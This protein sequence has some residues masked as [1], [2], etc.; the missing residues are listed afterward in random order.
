MACTNPPLL[1][2]QLCGA[3]HTWLQA[4]GLQDP[5]AW[6]RPY[7]GAEGATTR[8][9]RAFDCLSLFNADRTVR[10]APCCWEWIRDRRKNT[11]LTLYEF[12][13]PWGRMRTIVP[14]YARRRY[15]STKCRVHA[16]DRARTRT[17]TQNTVHARSA[18]AGSAR[19]PARCRDTR[20][21]VH[22]ISHVCF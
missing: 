7:V 22:A 14:R 11:E 8:F 16:Y 1:Y 15:V 12:Q 21:S 10:M 17:Y 4:D 3:C 18:A 19:P 6:T 2:W 5:V 20:A 13:A 9:K